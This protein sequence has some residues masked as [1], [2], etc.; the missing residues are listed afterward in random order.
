MKNPTDY[1]VSPE[2][3]QIIEILGNLFTDEHGETFTLDQMRTS[4]LFRELSDRELEGLRI[5]HAPGAPH[6]VEFHEVDPSD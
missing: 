4:A 5:T 6:D 1:L 2:G 3:T